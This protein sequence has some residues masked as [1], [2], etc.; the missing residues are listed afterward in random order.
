M[1]NKK[2]A[3]APS[4]NKLLHDA[5]SMVEAIEKTGK[6]VLL[7][8]VRRESNAL[9]D[10]L[11]TNYVT[12]GAPKLTKYPQP[13]G[14]TSTYDQIDRLA[15]DDIEGTL[16]FDEDQIDRLAQDDIE[17]TLFF[18]EDQIDRLVQDDIEG[19]LFF[20][21][22]ERAKMHKVCGLPGVKFV[23]KKRIPEEA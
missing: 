16:F 18:V 19:T 20:V 13:K 21:E 8:Y 23:R 22:E 5:R 15:Q 7:L 11:S 9:A 6:Q 14:Q 4:V 12:A 17:G 3:S 1:K 2:K 10:F